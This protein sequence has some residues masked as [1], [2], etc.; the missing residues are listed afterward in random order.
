MSQTGGATPA[1][2]IRAASLGQRPAVNEEGSG[3]RAGKAPGEF[4]PQVKQKPYAMEELIAADKLQG[5]LAEGNAKFK[6]GKATIAA[7]G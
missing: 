6:D 7:G 2:Q 5:R 4:A 1:L 3:A